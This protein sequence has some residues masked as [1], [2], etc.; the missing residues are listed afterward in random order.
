MKTVRD[1]AGK[2]YLVLKESGQASLVR[3][4][5]TGEECYVRNDRLETVDDDDALHAAARGVPRE[6]RRLLVGVHDDRWLGLLVELADRGPMTAR[7]LLE[8]YHL[9]ESDMNGLLSELRAADLVE[10]V[11]VGGEPGYRTT[12]ECERALSVV[13]GSESISAGD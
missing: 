4:P 5:E 3:D 11:D 7:Q 9:C 6:V 10:S 2:H 1:D 8:H 13:S 12:A